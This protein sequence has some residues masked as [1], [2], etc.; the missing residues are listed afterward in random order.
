MEYCGAICASLINIADKYF[1]RSMPV[2]LYFILENKVSGPKS[3]SVEQCQ[4]TN[5]NL[6]IQN[7]HQLGFF[8]LL[9]HNHTVLSENVYNNIGKQ[10]SY[11]IYIEDSRSDH[12]EIFIESYLKTLNIWEAKGRFVVFVEHSDKS[13]RLL[14][15]NC[16][17]KYN[18][19][20]VVVLEEITDMNVLSVYNSP[21]LPSV[22]DES[23]KAIGIYGWTS[24]QEPGNCEKIIILLDVFVS[25]DGG[26]FVSNT[27]LFKRDNTYKFNMC[28][29]V[30]STFEN[31]R[32]V[33]SRKVTNGKVTFERGWEVYLLNIILEALNASVYFVEH[34]PSVKHGG[35][36]NNGTAY[37][38]TGDLQYYRTDI[39]FAGLPII[40]AVTKI[41]DPTVSY[42]KIK[43]GWLVPCA[44]PLPHWESIFRI[45]APELWIAYLGCIFVSSVVMTLIAKCRKRILFLKYET[46]STFSDSVC[47]FYA[48]I[49]GGAMSVPKSET[50]R[51]FYFSWICY[52]FAFNTVL[53]TFL[54]SFLV[55]PLMDH[56]ISSVDEMLDSGIAFGYGRGYDRI[57][58]KIEG[59]KFQTILHN[60]QNCSTDEVCLQRLAYKSDFAVFFNR[61][62]FEYQVKYKYS[63]KETGR[64]LICSIPEVSYTSNYAMFVPKGHFVLSLMNTVIRRVLEAGLYLKFQ[65]DDEYLEKVRTHAGSKQFSE[66]EYFQLEVNH[67]QAPFTILLFGY[68]VS[69]LMF[70]SEIVYYRLCRPVSLSL[71]AKL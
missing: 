30:V 37:G 24:F 52:G 45:F 59:K 12:L 65:T 57:F 5:I 69:A 2:I 9:V 13:T 39:A 63:D 14:V 51:L 27:S 38:L 19:I 71:G 46:F 55:Q 53:Q 36:Y 68:V 6:L 22:K 54:T 7:I 4:F 31:H 50:L 18:V 49:I 43:Y 23:L 44:K 33:R 64:L 26:H 8:N 17:W 32:V 40:E 70:V 16:F 48:V 15:L 28:P 47:S 58:E 3:L 41:G 21:N 56:Q 61:L 34:D 66:S 11:L 25:I 42:S 10:F 29:L 60:R 62:R 67:L 20:D 35:H 1:K